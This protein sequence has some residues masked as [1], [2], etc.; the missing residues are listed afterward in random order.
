MAANFG[1]FIDRSPQICAAGMSSGQ[2]D[3][4]SVGAYFKEKPLEDS[5]TDTCDEELQT[6][7]VLE[8]PQLI[9]NISLEET[10]EGTQI[11][12]LLVE[13]PPVQ[14]FSK[15]LMVELNESEPKSFSHREDDDSVNELMHPP[16]TP[17]QVIWDRQVGHESVGIRSVHDKC[18]EA[19]GKYDSHGIWVR[20]TCDWHKMDAEERSIKIEADHV[21]RSKPQL[22]KA[23]SLNH[24]SHNID[25]IPKGN[26]FGTQSQASYGMEELLKDSDCPPCVFRRDFYKWMAALNKCRNTLRERTDRDFNFKEFFEKSSKLDKEKTGFLPIDVFYDVCAQEHVTFHKEEIESLLKVLKIIVDD[27]INYG[28]FIEIIDVNK[29]TIDIVPFH[30]LP[31]H[32]QYY[33]TSNQAARDYLIKSKAELP[34][35]GMTSTDDDLNEYNMPHTHK[36][37]KNL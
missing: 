14:E 31:E 35:A 32:N 6:E 21:N 4:D 16:R 27:K 1:K 8:P 30:D 3:K 26:S 25:S 33:V 29:P 22:G 18:F 12:V 23:L 9:Q 10:E 15:E 13:S 36:S 7:D 28:R 5:I 2:L 37:G 34:P 19:S 17:Y 11:K 24:I 20:C